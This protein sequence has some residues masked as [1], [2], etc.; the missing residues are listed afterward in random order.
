MGSYRGDFGRIVLCDGGIPEHLCPAGE[1]VQRLV[2]AA[3]QMLQGGAHDGPCTNEDEPDEACDLH[4]EA[5]NARLAA[6]VMAL[7]PFPEKP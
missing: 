4:I 5:Y 2:A 7:A 1:P 6:L 3:R